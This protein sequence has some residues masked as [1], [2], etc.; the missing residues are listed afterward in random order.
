MRR[1][2]CELFNDGALKR[3]FGANQ[4]CVPLPTSSFGRLN[5]DHHLPAMQIDR[6][7][8]EHSPG[9]EAGAALEGL[10]NPFVIEGPH[11]LFVKLKHNEQKLLTVPN[12][13]LKSRMP[14]RVDMTHP[15]H[16]VLDQLVHL[17]ALDIEQVPDGIAA[18]IPDSVTPEVVAN[19]LGVSNV[20]VSPAVS[21]DDGSVWL[22]GPRTVRIGTVLIAPPEA[23]APP[24]SLR[25]IESSAFGT[26][27][28][29]TT[30]LCIEALEEALSFE[31]P[32][33]VLDVGTGSGV[34]ALTALL[35][36]VPLAVGLDIDSHAL[37]IAGENARLNHMSDRLELVLGG[38]EAVPGLWTLVLAN[39]LASPL[40]EMAPVLVRRVAGRGRLIL[41]GIPSSLES[42]VRTSYERLGMR[43][44]RSESRG[45][46][47]VVVVQASW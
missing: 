2:R 35:K 37:K 21:R 19:A 7:T 42:E 45:G 17:G 23:T 20:R 41:S 31:V 25:L 43:H 38:P 9:D 8:A 44:V 22:L 34:L 26:G 39:V 5:Q 36:G 47:V 40:I 4:N 14:Y 1:Q 10:K 32:R 24:G 16:D 13:P 33:S 15:R 30:A 18:I 3:V 29:P 11:S 27:H 6:Q 46:W 12:F 28:H